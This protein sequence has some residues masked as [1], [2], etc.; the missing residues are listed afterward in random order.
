MQ[1]AERTGFL[2]NQKDSLE[3][4]LDN[5]MGEVTNPSGQNASDPSPLLLKL[6]TMKEEER[7]ELMKTQ[8][9]ERARELELWTSE[10]KAYFNGP[11]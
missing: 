11:S 7:I 4:C 8:S 6:R 5:Q 2:Q 3:K 9:D 10:R 1:T